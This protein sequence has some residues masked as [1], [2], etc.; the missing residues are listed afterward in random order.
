MRALIL[1][2]A[3][4]LLGACLPLSEYRNSLSRFKELEQEYD[5]LNVELRLLKKYNSGLMRS[6]AD[7]EAQIALENK[8]KLLKEVQINRRLKKL[9]IESNLSWVEIYNINIHQ[10]YYGE[11][12]YIEFIKMNP[13]QNPDT[14]R[15]ISWLTEKEKD[16]YYWLNYARIHPKEFCDTYIR[17]FLSK[18]G[19]DKDPYLL[20]LIDY[21]YAMK[22]LN[23]LVPDK[24]AF[25]SAKCHAV[26]SGKIGHTEAFRLETCKE[27]VFSESTD[28]GNFTARAH[29]I[30][31]LLSKNNP[32]LQS[33]YNCLD[34]FSSVGI[35]YS[36]HT[37]KEEILVIDFASKE[38]LR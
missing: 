22:P 16:T 7:L 28:Y 13:C 27:L 11:K 10:P 35:A 24:K 32:D 19:S 36:K 9:E 38:L 26:S 31:L 3:F 23:A 2:P 34:L 37:K 33:R 8:R 4:L 29:V 14:A 30:R 21:L 5:A 18:L 17:P 12:Y 6:L 1:F 15:N 20:S 25:E